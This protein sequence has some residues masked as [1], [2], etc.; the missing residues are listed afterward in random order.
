MGWEGVMPWSQMV[1]PKA[2]GGLGVRDL[3]KVTAVKR[4]AVY[5]VGDRKLTFSLIG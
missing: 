2:E 1:L 4:V 5:W 3:S